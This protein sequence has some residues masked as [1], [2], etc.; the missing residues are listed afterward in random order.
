VVGT[1]MIGAMPSASARVRLAAHEGDQF[2][3]IQST[4]A[5]ERNHTI[6]I[7][8]AIR[9][10]PGIEIGLDRVGLEIGE[11]RG[12]QTGVAQRGQRTARDRR[13]REPGIGDQQRLADAVRQTAL[14]QLG[15]AAC[16]KTH[17]GGV[18]PVGTHAHADVS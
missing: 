15:D 10:Q 13:I 14:G 17:G 4:A 9:Q 6:V 7:A 1:A 12:I 18:V 2:A 11:Q 5:T 16:A 3:G 8:A